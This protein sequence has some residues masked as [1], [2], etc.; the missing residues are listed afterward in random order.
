MPA[1]AAALTPMMLAS[2]RVRCAAPTQPH[3]PHASET[4]T[5]LGSVIHRL[6][7]DLRWDAEE[8]LAKL[9]GDY[10]SRK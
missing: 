8:D 3:K 9:F 6:W 7:R 1:A 2:R 10:Q 5:A 4:H